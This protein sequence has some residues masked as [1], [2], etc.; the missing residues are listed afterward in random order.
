ME[1]ISKMEKM[2][3]PKLEVIHFNTEDVIVTSGNSAAT[4]F[5]RATNLPDNFYFTLGSEVEQGTSNEE[6]SRNLFYK[7]NIKDGSFLL[8]NGNTFPIRDIGNEI[9]AWFD[10]DSKGWYTEMH[11]KSDYLLADGITYDWRINNRTS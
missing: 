5:I 7:F 8:A 10:E 6:L 3:A 9:Y 11:L 4:N 1:V 2:S